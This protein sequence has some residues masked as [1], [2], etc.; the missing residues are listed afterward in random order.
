MVGVQEDLLLNGLKIDFGD[1]SH[2]G[3]AADSN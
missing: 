3:T 1:E 2:R